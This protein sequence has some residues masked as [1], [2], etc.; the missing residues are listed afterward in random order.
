VKEQEEEKRHEE[1]A[2]LAF[3]AATQQ[4]LELF[5]RRISALEK[6]AGQTTDVLEQH[7]SMLS[8]L[9]RIV[10]KVEDAQDGTR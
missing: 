7:G 4:A 3:A 9:I 6:L 2:M 8:R 1:E 10:E 5:D